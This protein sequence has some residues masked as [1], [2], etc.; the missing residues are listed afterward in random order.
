VL[1]LRLLSLARPI[2]HLV[3]GYAR[4]LNISQIQPK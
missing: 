2:S 4:Q 3:P 1:S